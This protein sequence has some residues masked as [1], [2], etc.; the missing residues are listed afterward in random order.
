M[1]HQKFELNG[2]LRS[3][4]NATDAYLA[5]NKVI[6]LSWREVIEAACLLK[7]K[8]G[9]KEDKA[10]GYKINDKELILLFER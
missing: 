6:V 5:S 7:H 8:E 3:N 9:L 10:I 1:E 4:M 2:S